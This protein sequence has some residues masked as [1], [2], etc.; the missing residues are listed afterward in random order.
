MGRSRTF[1]VVSATELTSARACSRF[2]R[3]WLAQAAAAVAPTMIARVNRCV[4]HIASTR[5]KLTAT[6]TSMAT[7]SAPMATVAATGHS[8]AAKAGASERKRLK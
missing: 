3:T 5:P 8:D 7:A 2:W 1:W 6:A 4:C